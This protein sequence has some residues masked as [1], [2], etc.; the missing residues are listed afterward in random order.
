VLKQLVNKKKIIKFIL[1]AFNKNEIPDNLKS[2]KLILFTKNGNREPTLD[3]TRPIMV[4]SHIA[5]LIL[6]SNKEAIR[7]NE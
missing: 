5:K 1:K 7:K 4:L 3:D 2:F 6:K